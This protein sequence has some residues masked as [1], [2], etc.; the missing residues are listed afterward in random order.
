MP[1]RLVHSHP[2]AV[3]NPGSVS[4]HFREDVIELLRETL[5]VVHM[6]LRIITRTVGYSMT[7]LNEWGLND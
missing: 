6:D 4:C 2:V 1:R 5:E 7:F 3:M